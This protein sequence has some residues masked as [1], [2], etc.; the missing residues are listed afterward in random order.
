MSCAGV[1]SLALES[2]ASASIVMMPLLITVPCALIG[3]LHPGTRL[4]KPSPALI[5]TFSTSPGAGSFTSVAVEGKGRQS[6]SEALLTGL[7]PTML[8]CRAETVTI[9]GKIRDQVS[10]PASCVN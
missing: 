10:P 1:T 9:A 3:L 6:E 2:P 7:L 8:P 4:G 5:H